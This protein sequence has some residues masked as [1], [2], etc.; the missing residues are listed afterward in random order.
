MASPTIPKFD[1]DRPLRSHPWGKLDEN[2]GERHHLAHHCADVA[3]CLEE[4]AS[5]PV[6]RCRLEQAAGGELSTTVVQ[7]LAALGF[8]HDAGKLH[9][10]FQAKG[11]P[12]GVWR[13]PKCG[14]VQQGAALFSKDAPTG[15]HRSLCVEQLASWGVDEN[16]LYSSLAHHGRPFVMEHSATQLWDRVKSAEVDYDPMAAAELLGAALRRWFP[17]AFSPGDA[18]MPT[19][20]QFQHLFCGLV[21]LADW[22]GSDKRFFSYRSEFDRDYMQH[23]RDQARLAV[24]TIGLNVARH[25]SQ[26]AT[27][28]SFVN[29]TG[30]AAPRAAQ[31]AVD[32]FPLN[33]PMVILEAETGA[34][35][36][37]AAFWWFVRL[38]EAGKVDGLY[39]ALPTRS[40]AVQLHQRVNQM[41]KRLLGVGAPEAVLAVPGYLKAG[42]VEGEA[43]PGW[44]VLWED[45]GSVSEEELVARWAAESS[46]RYLAAMVAV[47]TVD[48]AMLAGLQ[49]K[50][51]HLRGAALSRSL[52]VIDEV[53][54]SDSYMT[55][56]Q[57]NLLRIHRERGGYALLMSATL[58]SRARCR[59]LGHA[60]PS[61][62][63]A[64]ETPYPAIWGIGRK[65]PVS[66][67]PPERNRSVDM[68]LISTMEAKVCARMAIQ[69]AQ[70]GARVLV[71]RN[72]VTAAVEVW[73]TVSQLGGE[74]LL[75]R[76]SSG[77]ALHHGR[78]APEDRR[79]LDRAVETALSPESRGTGGVIVIGTQTLE[80]SLDVDA[81]L[82]IT[83][84]CPIDVLLQRIG[85]LHRHEH[86]MRPTGYEKPRCH[87]L[88][89]ENGLEPLL[90]P[91]FCNGLGAWREKQGCN[92]IYR[93][94]SM[95]ELT[96]RLV[97][98]YPEWVLPAMNRLLVESA[99]HEERIEALHAELGKAWRDYRNDVVG[100]EIADRG[101]GR[102]VAL[103]TDIPFAEPEALFVSDE[104]RI[105]TRLGAEGARI[106]FTEAIPGPF[107]TAI[108]GITLP[109]HWSRGLNT[110]DPIRPR[111]VNGLITLEAGDRVFAYSRSGLSKGSK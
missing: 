61:F 24:A 58:G 66:I 52:L 72:T 45:E 49:V 35:K 28:V 11:W 39:F 12:A 91:A 60:A 94:L 1:S 97:S 43:L 40:S 4:L 22:I 59:W 78:F 7:R 103:H 51:A 73:R 82:L 33:E 110:K 100:Q 75:L 76:V 48:Q 36:T 18:E 92:G 63:N 71:I 95:L 31:R 70:C 57:N 108:S 29:V 87:V 26:L 62:E 10:G 105:R 77:P 41:L 30:C 9:P 102:L 23:A 111:L 55:E 47:G 83:D 93:D 32:E 56:V 79:L 16:L 34:G 107:G 89:P 15:M 96:R 69:A 106:T 81:D 80:Q 3:A 46:K 86:L 25:R 14:H 2:A 38:F 98:K 67:A 101:A 50:H 21:T 68:S 5:L 54:A 44:K 99:T 65:T 84:L 19:R 90:A 37:E 17:L 104:E 109:A 42:E 64:V 20:A 74:N 53:H 13:W 6:I 8:L 88:T 85:R 27:S